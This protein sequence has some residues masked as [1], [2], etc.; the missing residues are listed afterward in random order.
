MERYHFKAILVALFLGL[1]GN[2]YTQSPINDFLDSLED[3]TVREQYVQNGI[4]DAVF[5]SQ[6]MS[7][8]TNYV[9]YKKKSVVLFY[10]KMAGQYIY[11]YPYSKNTLLIATGHSSVGAF[12]VHKIY[13]VQKSS[14]VELI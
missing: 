10:N 13:V 1:A 8:D 6:L 5:M 3:V 2:A 14:L 9:L 12:T 7:Q 4:G 11:S